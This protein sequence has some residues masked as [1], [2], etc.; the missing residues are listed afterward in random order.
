MPSAE[1]ST[2]VAEPGTA[3]IAVAVA[4]A[5]FAATGKRIRKLPIADQLSA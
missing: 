4:N 5:L 2:G 3:P 1:K